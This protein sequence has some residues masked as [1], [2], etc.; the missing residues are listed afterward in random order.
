MK[1]VIK[2][3][4]KNTRFQLILMALPCVILTLAFFYVPL[5]G[6]GIAFVDYNPGLGI[7]GSP[8]VGLKNFTAALKD[9][10]LLQVLRNTLALSGLGLMSSVLAPLCA[11]LMY[12]IP[13]RR[14]KKVVQSIIT[15]P[16]YISWV[17]VGSIAYVILNVDN[18]VVNVFLQNLGLI[19]N[20]INF[21]NNVDTTWILQTLI[22]L[23]KGLGF[24]LIV[25]LAAVVSIDPTLYEAARVDGANRLQLHLHITVP[26]L[27]PTFIVLFIISLGNIL[28]N[29]FEQYYVF[30]NTMIHSR[31]Q[32][33]DFFLWRVGFTT[34]DFGYSTA[35][36][37]SKT[38]ISLLMFMAGNRV[39]KAIRGTPIF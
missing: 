38:F 28:S 22:G 13:F 32:T 36:G 16:N 5:F 3:I 7:L 1:Q 14:F 9:P 19:Q 35:L 26:G 17:L 27:M 30:Y 39:V 15:L 11:I 23:W 6:W 8:F 31:I 24:S 37:L 12:E 18:G 20:K 10:E 34:N 29:G 21:L 2:N 33:L 4:T 25:Y